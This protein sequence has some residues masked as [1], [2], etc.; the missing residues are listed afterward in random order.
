MKLGDKNIVA[1]YLGDV[2]VFT[3]YYGVSFPIEPQSTL[4][5]RTGYMPW[6]KELPILLM[7]QLNILMLQIE[8]SMK[9]VLIET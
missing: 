3:N 4:L 2:N 5:T 7:E 6:H 9:M 8:P 1:A